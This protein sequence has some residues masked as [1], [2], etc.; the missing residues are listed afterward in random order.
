MSIEIDG[1][2][3]DEDFLE[4]KHRLKPLFEAEPLK[5]QTDACLRRF[6]RGFE[7]VDE[8]YS[9]LIKYINWREEYGVNCLSRGDDDIEEQLALDKAEVLDFPD[10]I[11]RPVVLVTV[12]NHDS[13]TRDLNVITKFIVYILEEA[14]RKCDED[15]IDNLCITF[16][17]KGFSFNN[18]DYGFVKQL[19]W[20]LSRR[21][22]ERLGKCL[23]VNAPFIFSGCWAL[24]RLWLHEV[25]SS[26]IVFI[27]NEEHLAE[28][29]P[30]DILPKTLF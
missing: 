30:L 20:L 23:I 26:K 17:L 8:A 4:L 19:I 6:L 11:G 3:I 18:M 12:R 28:Y 2:S 13:R 10:H 7:D 25:T 14:T 29:I 9:A 1:T 21:Y 16:D 15:I 27:K 22:P 24:I 5:V